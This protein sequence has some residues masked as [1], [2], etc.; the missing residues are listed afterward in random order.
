MEK[1]LI[2]GTAFHIQGGMQAHRSFCQGARL[3]GTEYVH[4]SEVFNGGKPFHNNF[5]ACH[6]FRAMG[7]IDTDDGRQQLRR[8][9]HRQGQGK[10]KSL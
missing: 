5:V 1:D 6:G 4:A 3:V 10:E 9:P 7:Q 8:Q 2:A